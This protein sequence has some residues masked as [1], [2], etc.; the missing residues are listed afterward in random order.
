MTDKKFECTECGASFS[1]REALRAH[2]FRHMD[3]DAAPSANSGTRKTSDR[4]D[5]K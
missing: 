4:D 5:S 3:S 2:V 1:T